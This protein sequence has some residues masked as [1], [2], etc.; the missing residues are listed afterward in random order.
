MHTFNNPKPKRQTSSWS[1]PASQLWRFLSTTCTLAR[2]LST[3]KRT[4]WLKIVTNTPLVSVH[5]TLYD[6]YTLSRGQISSACNIVILQRI[7]VYIDVFVSMEL[8]I[9]VINLR[10][11][12][13]VHVLNIMVNITISPS[14][15]YRS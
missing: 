9:D 2:L 6:H 13:F 8:F 14:Q 12:N 7:L 11:I 5:R 1:W 10:I 3:G 15:T 4:L